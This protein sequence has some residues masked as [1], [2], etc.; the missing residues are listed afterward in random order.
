MHTFKIFLTLIS[1]LSVKS[2]FAD[3]GGT[4]L[5][6]TG[7]PWRAIIENLETV[8][9]RGYSAIILSPHT[10]TCSGAFG[11]QGYDPSNFQSFDG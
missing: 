2:I 11:G 3:K 4:A 9:N 10:A 1:L 5:A 8:K 6:L 7:W